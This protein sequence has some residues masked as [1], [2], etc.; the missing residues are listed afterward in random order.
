MLLFEVD[1]WQHSVFS[2]LALWIVKH[3][4]AVEH[5]LS[6]FVSGFVC[7]TAYAFAFQQVEEALGNSI[8]VAVPPAAQA[9]FQIVLLQE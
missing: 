6:C 2:M 5:I 8:V 4:G 7:F 9:V 3:R 1:W